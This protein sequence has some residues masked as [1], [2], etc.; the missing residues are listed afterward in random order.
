MFG[1]I[2]RRPRRSTAT[3]GGKAYAITGHKWFL[4]AP[5]SDAFLVLAQAKGGLSCFFMPRFSPDGSVNR[6]QIER[7]KDKLGNRSN[8]SAEVTF[9]RAVGY[10]DQ[11]G[12]ERRPHHHRHGDADAARLRRVLGGADAAGARPCAPSCAA[13]HRVPEEA[14]RSAADAPGARRHGARCRGRDRARLQARAR[15]STATT[16]RTRPPIAG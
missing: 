16:I 15:P 6:L 13:S 2:R 5:M 9:D 11:R 12:G 8:G 14:D 3:G 10:L 1:P 4:S 7:L